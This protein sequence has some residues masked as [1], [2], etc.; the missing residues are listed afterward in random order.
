MA[1]KGDEVWPVTRSKPLS[2]R[3]DPDLSVKREAARRA[4]I[5]IKELKR[6]GSAANKRGGARSSK[7]T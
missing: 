7:S 5:V 4:N 2:T 1:K 6:T 3:L